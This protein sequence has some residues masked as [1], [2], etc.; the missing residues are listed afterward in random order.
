MNE[1]KTKIDEIVS[2]GKCMGLLMLK[3]ALK[4]SELEVLQNLDERKT[5]IL[6]NDF[7]DKVWEFLT[8]FKRLTLF[9]EKEGNIFEIDTRIGSGKD[10]M[11][12]FNLFEKGCLNG[13]LVKDSVSH[14][15][16]LKLPFMHLTSYQVVFLGK[17]GNSIFSLY[18]GRE[19]HQH[20]ES[21][22]EKFMSFILNNKD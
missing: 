19:N 12:Y 21:E 20:D 7:F 4:V 9:L 14:I 8:T 1:L 11:G 2:S 16:L 18:L 10:G 6:G 5:L 15:A 22:I 17:D 3:N 13:H